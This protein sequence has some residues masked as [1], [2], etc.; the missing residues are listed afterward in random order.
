M[1]REEKSRKEKK[2][3]YISDCIIDL[4]V[5]HF[6]V[7]NWFIEKKTRKRKKE[8]EKRNTKNTLEAKCTALSTRFDEKKKREEEYVT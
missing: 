8:I 7:H 2:S 4:S 3:H 5:L 1:R 6:T